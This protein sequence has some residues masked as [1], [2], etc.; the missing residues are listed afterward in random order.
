VSPIGE[1]PA[2]EGAASI[3][4]VGSIEA[5]SIDVVSTGAVSTAAPGCGMEQLADITAGMGNLA[6]MP[7]IRHA[8]QGI[9]A[10]S[11]A[12]AFTVVSIAAVSTE[13]VSI[14]GEVSTGV[15]FTGGEVS[16]G[17]AESLTIVGGD[18]GKGE[19]KAHRLSPSWLA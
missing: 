6:V 16:P 15:A 3:E 7:P 11:I 18:N 9:M 10:E 2:T 8:G 17:A 5:V 12:P 13:V 14:A 1:E 4:G 19:A